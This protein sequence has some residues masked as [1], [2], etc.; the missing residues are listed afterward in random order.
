MVL[1]YILIL[2]LAF[3]SVS[4][5]E[6]T[7]A[8]KPSAAD[9]ATKMLP[10]QSIAPPPPPVVKQASLAADPLDGI[11]I[12]IDAVNETFSSVMYMVATETGLNLIMSPDVDISKPFTLTVK[13]MPAK[14]VLD[15]IAENAGIYY[16]IEGNALKI[17]QVITQSFKIPYINTNTDQSSVVGGDIFGSSDSS[18]TTFIHG[19]YTI[20]YSTP[21]S[22]S[23]IQDQIIGHIKA[24]MFPDENTNTSNT[25]SSTD[26]AVPQ[27]GSATNTST[28]SKSTKSNSSKTTKSTSGNS[29]S[30]VDDSYS[31]GNEGYYFNR[32]TGLLTITTTPPKMKIIDNFLKNILKELNKQVL[33]EARLVEVVLNN[34]NAYGINWSGK[35]L[36]NS[37]TLNMGYEATKQTLANSLNPVGVIYNSK[38]MSDLFAFMSSQGRVETVGNPR[39]RVMNGQ[40]A[41][42]SSGQLLPYWELST[43]TNS[44]T[45]TDTVNYSRVMVLDGLILGVTPYIKDDN[46]VTISIVPIFSSVESEKILTN[47]AGETVASYPI[48]NMKEAGTVLNMNSGNTVVMGGLISNVEN[49]VEYKVPFLSNIPFLGNIFKSKSKTSEKRELVIFLTTTVIDG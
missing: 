23:S 5:A 24:V 2:I 44:D 13:N 7:S 41:M 18:S 3:L 49:N 39:L 48:V 25:Q 17:K 37:T 9:D 47:S 32:F 16:S 14:Q 42:I 1:R 19:D 8:D 6:V 45:N 29:A 11:N 34:N 12:S 36:G 4:C 40:S 28:S 30:T 35:L 21:A 38:D 33:I 26:A 43:S 20:N 46:T 22:K 15:I 27:T 31:K 10:P